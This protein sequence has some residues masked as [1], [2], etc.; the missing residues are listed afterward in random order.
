M[1]QFRTPF[2]LPTH[3]GR[4]IGED[5][6]RAN[7]LTEAEGAFGEEATVRPHDPR[8][9]V[10]SGHLALMRNDLALADER[11][12]AAVARDRKCREAN[13]LLAEVSYRRDDFAVA[14][15]LYA[16]A[17]NRPVAAKLRSFAGRLPYD[18]EGP[19][20]VRL[21]FA[22][23]DPLPILRARVNSGPEVD[24][25]LDTGGAELILDESFARS[26]GIPVFGGERSVFG[27]GKTATLTHAAVGS[28]ALGDL[29]I[30]NLPAHVIDLEQIGSMLGVATLSGIVGTSL[31]YRFLATIDYP[32]EALV[33]RPRGASSPASAAIIDVPMLMA[34]D[35]FLLAE[36]RLND[37]P[38]TMLFVDSGLAGGAFAC[39]AS[40]L[41][42][43]GIERGSTQ[44]VKGRGGGGEMT[45]WPFDVSALSLGQARREGLQGIAGAFPPQLEWAYGFRIGGLVSHGFLRAYAVTFD[46]DRMIIRLDPSQP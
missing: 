24:L 18:I 26:G 17:G 42:E 22:R 41:K 43:A 37:G 25:L 45:A 29:T 16:A 28:L 30:R 12:S 13:E 39:P 19:D 15:T 34:D 36:G 6:L 7:R 31:L 20:T 11:L 5:L 44:I 14:A 35:H 10:A 32:A 46:F 3:R 2:H 33:L 8:P 40:T 27:G 38:P 23:L 21:P 1:S 4:S 9:L